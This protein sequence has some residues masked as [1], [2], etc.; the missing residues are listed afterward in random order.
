M[1]LFVT[2][3]RTNI[4]QKFKIDE[5]QIYNNTIQWWSNLLILYFEK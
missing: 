4:T 5:Y 3:V 2:R 1:L